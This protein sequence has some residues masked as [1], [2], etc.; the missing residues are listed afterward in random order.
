MTPHLIDQSLYIDD[1]MSGSANVLEAFM[2]H[3]VAKHIMKWG[4]FNLRKWNLNSV[5]LL[6]LIRQSEPCLALQSLSPNEDKSPE[7][8]VKD[9]I[10]AS[11]W[12]LIETI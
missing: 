1:L 3:K 4:G 6:K 10:C 8:P 5:E 11:C 7:P 9:L 12:V 2:L